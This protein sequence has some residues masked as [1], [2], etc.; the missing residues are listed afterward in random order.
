MKKEFVFDTESC[1]FI[2]PTIL[3]QYQINDGPII[4]HDIWKESAGKTCE[5][6]EEAM[7]SKLIGFNMAHDMY[8]LSFTY[9]MCKM[10]GPKEKLNTFEFMEYMYLEDA[11]KYCL[12]PKESLDLMVYGQKGEF[13]AIMKQKPIV[14]KRIP[15]A[16]ATMLVRELTQRVEINPIYFAGMKNGYQWKIKELWS[17]KHPE[18]GWKE[19]TPE[20]YSK[21]KKGLLH[22]HIEP[23]FVNLVL[24]FNPKKRL[25]DIMKYILG[26]KGVTYFETHA[27]RYRERFWLPIS[28]DWID[29]FPE[30]LEMWRHNKQQRK[31]ARNDIV[32]TRKLYDYFGKP[33][34][35]SDDDILACAVGNTYWKGWDFDEQKAGHLLKKKMDIVA[36]C[37]GF[38]NFNAP[39]QVRAYLLKDENP[40]MG[41]LI[42]STKSET[43]EALAEQ[44]EELGDIARRAQIVLDGR[45]ADKEKG[46]LMKML[47]AGKMFVQFKVTGTK[48]NR[49][50]G[51]SMEGKGESINPQGIPSDEEFREIILF[52]KRLALSGGDA[53]SF[54]VVIMCKVYGDEGLTNEI[55]SGRKFHAVTASFLYNK[56]YE[57][58]YNDI[59]DVA[60]DK[61]S[62]DRAKRYNFAK[63]YG[64]E[65]QKLSEVTGLS[66]EEIEEA[67]AKF[68]EKYPGVRAARERIWNDFQALRQPN[69]E[70]TAVYW[71][72]PKDYV[73]SFMGFKRFFTVEIAVMKTLFD[74]AN[75]LPD[76][77]KDLGKHIKVVRRE[78]VQTA[79]GATQSALFG[80][81]F[82]MQGQIMRAASNHRIQSPGTSI[83]KG[84]NALLV[85]TFQPVGV[86]P[87]HFRS[88]NMHDELQCSHR[89][90]YTDYI[91]AVV[92]KYQ[93]DTQGI[94]PMFEMEWSK[95][96]KN[97][98]ESH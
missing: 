22:L 26:E 28:N 45:H 64:A 83:I 12:T 36:R 5:I 3:L 43:L 4:L 94:L 11:R 61:D 53:K 41:E 35:N 79:S 98:K 24:P 67:N 60:I 70:G 10:F 25:K 1:G 71:Q 92:K 29:V 33:D 15:R 73:T 51:G 23:D 50:A 21:H 91:E 31:Y 74:L 17:H 95:N 76:D 54:E 16:I 37:K 59:K 40:M 87:Y 20:E 93:E 34:G 88:F 32:Y 44:Q 84:L 13:Q 6:I 63:A 90:E 89:K 8:H 14:L 42:T 66:V 65:S 72:Q 97:W 56:T 85:K 80:A 75:D 27:R 55:M 77:L 48:T 18:F 2:G 39:K 9:N 86:Q 52:D 19:I 81:A 30:H 7:D 47:E 46:L 49:M 69:G 78:R 58:I 57:E 68:E 62:Y 82:A 96:A 38:V